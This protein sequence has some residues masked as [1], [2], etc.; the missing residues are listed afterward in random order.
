MA[1]KRVF[2]ATKGLAIKK[3]GA[4][5]GNQVLPLSASGTNAS[6]HWEVPR[7]VQSVGVNTTFNFDQVF[8]QGQLAIYENTEDRPDVEVTINR[9]L[10]G[11]MPLYL[12]ATDESLI[13][14]S[15][16]RATLQQRVTNYRVNIA[17]H[18]YPETNLHASGTADAQMMASGMYLSSLTYTF[19]V[20]GVST[21]ELSFIGNDK[22]W[23]SSAGGTAPDAHFPSGGNTSII[24]PNDE[25]AT[26]N[27]VFPVTNVGVT[28]REDFDLSNSTLPTGT[29]GI[30]T[31]DRAAIT[32]ISVSLDLNLEEIFVLG[33]K[34]AYARTI[35]F[36]VEV[37]TTIEVVTSEGDKVEALSSV[38]SNV[39]NKSIILKTL[40]GLT[41]DLGSKNKLQSVDFSGGDTSGGNVTITYTYS[42]FNDFTLYHTGYA[43]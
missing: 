14:G 21:E 37:T 19:P 17:L 18:I 25:D 16:A 39:S 26:T 28:R 34:G 12:I 23:N 7:G 38:N 8:Q 40:Q 6:N 41:I 24:G 4:T 22:F 33:S 15:P 2:Y 32:N 13:S 29:S 30:P 31:E 1:N 27:A 36:P 20:D 5:A 43:H 35:S 10:D 11:T 9:V 42:N 3:T